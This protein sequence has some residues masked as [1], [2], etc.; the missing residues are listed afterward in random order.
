MALVDITDAGAVLRAV[1]EFKALG[2][3]AFLAR[4]G[5]GK[6]REY[7]L[8]VGG[9][10]FD[11]KAIIGAAHGHQFP[12]QGPLSA[13]DFSGGDATVKT[14]LEQLGFSVERIPLNRPP[15]HAF[16]YSSSKLQIGAT[17]TRE[18]LRVG[19]GITDAT[20]HT[21]L[22]QPRGYSSLWIFLTE[23]KTPDRT[24]YEDHLDGDTLHFQ[25]QTQ[26]RKDH[27][28]IEHVE[29]NLELLL[30]NRKAKYEF[31]GAGF[32]YEG[33]FRYVSHSGQR[34]SS[35]ILRRIYDEVAQQQFQAE[36]AKLFDP[37][38]VHDGRKR[39]LRAIALRRGQRAFRSALIEAYEGRCPVTGCD[40]ADALEAAHIFP[41]QGD[42]TNAVSN[43]LLLRADI[44]VLFDLGMISIDPDNLTVVL[45]ETLKTTSYS[46]LDGMRVK[47]PK[48]PSASP[49]RHALQW[50]LRQSG[51]RDSQT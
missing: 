23:R 5:F 37:D 32:R 22:F 29:R 12:E 43:G 9:E 13:S 16:Q 40:C 6:A 7:F 21:G 49:S 3:T 50:H 18:Q 25:G 36:Q 8:V 39:Q 51:L 26:G 20:L 44:H 48:D 2:Q 28:I 45:A 24:Q 42:Q 19:F 33:P 30:F 38:D 27:L 41:Y 31:E 17:Y 35:F 1:E 15:V 46:A 11:S 10:R 14:K 34:P 47:I 4:Y